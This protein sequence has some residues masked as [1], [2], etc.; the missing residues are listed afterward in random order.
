MFKAV[1]KTSTRAIDRYAASLTA[2]PWYFRYILGMLQIL[3]ATFLFVLVMFMLGLEDYSDWVVG[4]EIL[5]LSLVV[6][7]GVGRS[8]EFDF[9]NVVRETN[10][11]IEVDDSDITS[12][13]ENP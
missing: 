13:E 3:G 12:T 9:I 8:Y 1:L 10:E 11:T 4:F 6:A 7:M 2:F 5:A